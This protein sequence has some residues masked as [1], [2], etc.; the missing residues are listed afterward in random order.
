MSVEDKKQDVKILVVSEFPLDSV[1]A[2]SKRMEHAKEGIFEYIR[3]EKPDVIF[4]DGLI[5]SLYY[6]ETLHF[7]DETMNKKD[8]RSIYLEKSMELASEFLETVKKAS[9]DS[10]IYLAKTHQ[11]EKNVSL[12][13]NIIAKEIKEKNL[14]KGT[15]L[16]GELAQIEE[17][18]KLAQASG[19]MKKISHFSGKKGSLKRKLMEMKQEEMRKMPQQG[20]GLQV[21]AKEAS[22]QYYIET[23]QEFNPG[24]NIAFENIIETEENGYRIMYAHTYPDADSRSPKTSRANSLI[25][26]VQKLVK[27][28]SPPDFILESGHSAEPFVHPFRHMKEPGKPADRYS[29]IGISLV[30][31]DQEI[32]DSLLSGKLNNE[33][34][35]N[36]SDNLEA[37]K[38]VKKEPA[39]G[40][41]IFGRDSSGFYTTYISLGD[42]VEVGKGNIK[43]KEREFASIKVL[44]DIHIGKGVVRRDKLKSALSRFDE[45]IEGCR[46]SKKS[47]SPVFV[48]NESLQG[49]NYNTFPVEIPGL[50]PSEVEEQSNEKM[51]ELIKKHGANSPKVA[52]EYQEFM[53]SKIGGQNLIRLDDQLREYYN[54]TLDV[55]T[56]TL[57]FCKYH[58]ALVFTEA[59]HIAHTVGDKGLLETGLQELPFYTF[60]KIYKVLVETGAVNDN[61]DLHDLHKKIIRTKDIDSGYIT[62]PFNLDGEVYLI[63]AEH[64]PG[65]SYPGANYTQRQAQRANMRV[66]TSDMIFAAHI[67]SAFFSVGGTTGTNRIRAH[68]KGATFSEYDSYGKMGGWGAPTIGYLD[69]S[70]PKSGKKGVYKVQFVLSDVL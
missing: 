52:Q 40:I 3:Q 10:K 23:L 14:A 57:M 44:S 39:A 59:T 24:I 6:P 36:I 30:M 60:D 61:P 5:S 16:E 62:F 27:S 55:L 69:V 9:P 4:V 29:L 68:I 38:R 8:A 56:K 51:E 22:F 65:S 32:L 18:L 35:F 45:E 49:Y 46:K 20:S 13:E 63:S 43:L 17:Q 34:F 15:E 70:L 33:R 2:N 48:L 54:L 19:E 67:H 28:D 64:K 12:L 37:V 66:D 53:L 1:I 58:P 25:K 47:C 31:E 7:F 26:Y 11:D 42:L 41:S 50:L 21:A